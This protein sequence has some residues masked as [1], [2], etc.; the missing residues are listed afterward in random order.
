MMY[1]FSF[2]FFF[3]SSDEFPKQSSC[4]NNHVGTCLQGTILSAFQS[5]VVKLPKLLLYHCGSL[6][7]EPS[8]IPK[9]VLDVVGCNGIVLDNMITCWDDFRTAF[10]ANRSDPS[11]CR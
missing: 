2:L 7:Y 5:E 3:F 8:S 11:L 9:L 4:L 1:I 10:D 6:G